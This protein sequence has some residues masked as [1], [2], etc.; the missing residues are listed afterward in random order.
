MEFERTSQLI[1]QL[2][3]IDPLKNV[4]NF[5]HLL[6]QITTEA[7]ASSKF[8]EILGQNPKFWV[9]ITKTC[10]LAIEKLIIGE[11][12]VIPIILWLVRTFRN[13]VATATENQ[14]KAL[15]QEWNKMIEN[16]LWYCLSQPYSG[17]DTQYVTIIRSGMQA[18]S[19]LITGN[20]SIQESIWSDFMS[21]SESNNLL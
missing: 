9:I 4:D 14:N 16:I 21:R 8:R 2:E 13:I 20:T 12:I 17:D 3:T 15:E 7:Q 11:I 6:K 5:V 1:Q 18:L 10:S 19:N